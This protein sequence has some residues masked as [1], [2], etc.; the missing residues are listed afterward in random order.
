MLEDR[1]TLFVFDLTGRRVQ[2]G[3]GGK[4]DEMV[5][6]CIAPAWDVPSLIGASVPYA[7]GGPRVVV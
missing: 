5:T 7:D 2:A 6:P 1:M 4:G 3:Y